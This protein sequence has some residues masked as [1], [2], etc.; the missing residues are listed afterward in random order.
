MHTQELVISENVWEFSSIWLL[1][2]KL[3]NDENM[4]DGQRALGA[5]NRK[6]KFSKVL[7]KILFMR[8]KIAVIFIK[9]PYHNSATFSKEFFL[10]NV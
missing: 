7:K 5:A 10:L 2:E 6:K 8:W 1:F 9:S 3:E 4:L